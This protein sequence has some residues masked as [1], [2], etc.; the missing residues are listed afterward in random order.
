MKWGGE[1]GEREH[2]KADLGNMQGQHA[3]EI[4]AVTTGFC[5]IYL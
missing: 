3:L 4:V 1:K 5:L 2:L